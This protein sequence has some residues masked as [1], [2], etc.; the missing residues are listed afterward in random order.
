MSQLAPRSS[1]GLQASPLSLLQLSVHL[2]YPGGLFSR[3]RSHLGGGLVQ[4]GVGEGLGEVTAQ[5]SHTDLLSHLC[6]WF[7]LLWGQGAEC[8]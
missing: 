2:A 8:T 7:P 1:L 3:S 6:C 5:T 4:P